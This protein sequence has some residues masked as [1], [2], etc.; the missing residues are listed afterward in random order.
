MRLEPWYGRLVRSFPKSSRTSS[1]A[2]HRRGRQATRLWSSALSISRTECLEDRTLLSG[3][4]GT[5]GHS[6]TL[7]ALSPSQVTA[8]DTYVAAADPSYT[9]SLNSTITGTGYTDYVINMV[10]QTWSPQPGV[11]EV[12]QHW[13]QII[14]PT[15]V[16]STT[17]VLNIENGLADLNSTTPP[18]AADAYSV[19]TATTLNAITVFLPTVP[20]EPESFPS[21]GETTPLTEDSLVAFT[22]EQYLDGNG[23]DWP[24]LLPMVKSAVR[25]MDTTQSF[26][27]SESGGALSVD[28]FIVTGQS[29]RGWT[30]WLTPAVDSRVIAIVPYDFDALNL[31]EQVE[32]QLDTYVGV[33]QDIYDGDSTAVEPYVSTFNSFGTP[34]G[35]SLLSI[36]DPYSYIERPTYDIPIYDVAST[37]DQFFVPGAQFYFNDLP[38]QN[39]LRYVPNTDH[40]LDTDAYQGGINFEKAVVDGAALPQFTWTVSNAGTEIELNSVTT[41]TSV[42]MW[43]ATDPNSRDFR[44][45]TFGA[46]WT[47]STLTDQGGGT[48]VAQVTPPTTG[49]TD[50]FIQMQY[51]VDGLTLTFTTQIS[52]TPLLTPIV[53]ASDPVGNFNGSPF[54]ATA[55][56]TGPAGLP[57]PGS[58]SFTYYPGNNTGGTTLPSAPTSPG[59]YT[60]VASFT[61]SDPDYANGTS[62]FV[63]FQ[64]FK[65]A[66]VITVIDSGGTFNGNP[67]PG[68]ATIAGVV[69]G[70]DDTPGS[71]LEGVPVTI[72]YYPGINSSGPPLPGPPTA[73]GQYE[74]E[75]VFAGSQDYLSFGRVY[76][77]PI[78]PAVPAITVTAPSGPFNGSPFVA[79]ATIAGVVAGVDNTPGSTLE[80]V[81]LTFSYFS[82][83][84]FN[85]TPI[86]GPPTAPGTYAVTASFAGSEDYEEHGSAV[87]FVISPAVPAISL[88]DAGGTYNGNAFPATATIAGVVSGVDDTPAS[89]LEGVPLNLSYFAGTTTTGTPLSGA[90]TNAGQY[91][92]LASFAGSADYG[93]LRQSATFQ[94]GQ[95]TPIVVASDAGGNFTG[96]PFPATATATGVGGATVSGTFAFT[97]YVGGTVNGNGA[98]T[99]PALR[100]RI[101]SSPGSPAATR[102]MS[103]VH[104]R[105]CP[106]PSPSLR[107]SWCQAWWQR[108]PAAYSTAIP[109]LRRRRR[110]ESAG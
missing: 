23:Q 67:F 82:G 104:R 75:A 41:P 73:V 59:I 101:P 55:T 34:Q 90:P 43:Q 89:S 68:T 16:N 28:N 15:T 3:T 49:A 5:P 79:T 109:L 18:T 93:P 51:T 32:S 38:G 27:S 12:W 57:V 29:K 65:A 74:A 8:L 47:S 96:D 20:N 77:F 1:R 11:S 42:T 83:G 99:A 24:I 36:I 22:F 63:H 69:P 71:R 31:Q 72:S 60:A 52:T 70:V 61:S 102:T 37:G 45:E 85:G 14:V 108:T 46:N 80:G 21:L 110:R 92:A 54:A 78:L 48:Y 66:P 105:A 106:S 35:E 107:P 58:F 19:Q 6:S 100:E 40:S 53:V 88:T 13:L 26:V 97:Y 25:A 4:P 76:V 98:S 91:T 64:I 44:L 30:T 87:A 17:A 62:Q 2:R 95:A 84:L 33:T 81:G 56:A 86:P 50:F 9:F 94:I 10:S 103:L 7:P 39:Y